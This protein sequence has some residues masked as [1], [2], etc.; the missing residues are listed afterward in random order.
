MNCNSKWLEVEILN[1]LQRL[2]CLSLDRTPAAE[3]LLGTAA[4]WAEGAMHG[5]EWERH[6][7]TGR[8]RAAFTTLIRTSRRWPAPVEFLEA[9]PPV[10]PAPAVAH[11]RK[12]ASPGAAARAAEAVAAIL[13]DVVK[14]VPAARVERESSAEQRRRTEAE[15][16]RHYGKS[17]AAG[18][19]A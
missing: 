6:R 5:T 15:L 7:D 1:G 11:E 9:L 14:A 10:P 12:P 3:M 13:G 4:A 19:D 17:A 16:S 2:A 8:V 18:P